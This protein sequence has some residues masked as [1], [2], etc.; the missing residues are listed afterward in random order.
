MITLLSVCMC[1]PGY[2]L[3]NA[4]MDVMASEPLH[5]SLPS[6]LCVYM[7]AQSVERL[8]AGWTTEG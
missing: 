2:R 3:L 6:S 8:A 5:K 7:L 4:G 1:V